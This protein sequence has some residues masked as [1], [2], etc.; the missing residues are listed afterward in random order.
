MRLS[1]ATA[2]FLVTFLLFGQSLLAKEN[3]CLTKSNISE[4][5]G[6]KEYHFSNGKVIYLLGH[7]HFTPGKK[8]YDLQEFLMYPSA[9]SDLND[10]Q[11]IRD[12]YQSKFEQ[13][14][15][16]AETVLNLLN[17]G[18]VQTLA[19]EGPSQVMKD[20]FQDF[21]PTL[22]STYENLSGKK[23]KLYEEVFI[24]LYGP[25]VIHFLHGLDNLNFDGVDSQELRGLSNQGFDEM[26]NNFKSLAS[27]SSDSDSTPLSNFEQCITRSMETNQPISGDSLGHFQGLFSGNKGGIIKKVVDWRNIT[28]KADKDRDIFM[29]IELLKKSGNV[30]YAVGTAHFEGIDAHYNLMKCRN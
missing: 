15:G 27:I 6:V 21:F 18:N 24:L 12:S 23:K 26:F 16:N 28:I 5:T 1:F 22:K 29:A 13:H 20:K 17:S 30:F 8:Y 2:Y 7:S 3:I 10:I 19:L 9:Y 4:E 14:K 11:S 25:E